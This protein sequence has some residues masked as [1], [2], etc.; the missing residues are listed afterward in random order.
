MNRPL[1]EDDSSLLSSNATLK[2]V[3]VSYKG[4][5]FVFLAVGHKKNPNCPPHGVI[6]LRPS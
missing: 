6:R 4:I 3:I 5:L 2:D 1:S